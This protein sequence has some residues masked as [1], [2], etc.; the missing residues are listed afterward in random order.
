ML[1]RI[2][3]GTLLAALAALAGGCGGT[4][5]PTTPT[6]NPTTDTFTGTLAPANANTHTFFTF[7]GGSV[8]ATLT[9]VGPDPTQTIGFSLGTFNATTSVCTVVLDNSAALQAFKFTATASTLGTFCVR[10]YD[11]GSVKTLSDAGTISDGNP[12]TYTV[13]VVHP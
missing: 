9:A 7:A 5:T 8:T 3:R 2:A 13:T 10:V 11:N 12:F 6:V 4:T 1:R